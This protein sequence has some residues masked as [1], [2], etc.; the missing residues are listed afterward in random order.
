MDCIAVDLGLKAR[1]PKEEMKV[2]LYF[3]GVAT[4]SCCFV[5]S[6]D[7]LETQLLFGFGCIGVN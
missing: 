7:L 4:L 6:L 2:E 5:L 1:L 3:V